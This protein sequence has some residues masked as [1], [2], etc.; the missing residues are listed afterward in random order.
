MLVLRFCLDGA[1]VLLREH[2][3]VRQATRDD[4]MAGLYCK[5]PDRLH[6]SQVVDVCASTE[7]FYAEYLHMR[8]YACARVL[9]VHTAQ[10]RGAASHVITLDDWLT[11]DRCLCKRIAAAQC[12]SRSLLGFAARFLAGLVI[13][14][15]LYC[16][17][18]PDFADLIE[19][20]AL[21]R[22]QSNAVPMHV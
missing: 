16:T 5:L 19:V 14:H 12:G 13:M 2:H 1:D 9:L 7:F 10:L 11:F 15:G 21:D 17:V 4:G 6:Q 8:A 22:H 3:F 20:A 18:N